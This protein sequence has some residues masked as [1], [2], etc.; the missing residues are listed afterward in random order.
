MNVSKKVKYT[1]DLNDKEAEALFYGL[2]ILHKMILQDMSDS[3]MAELD[4]TI[5]DFENHQ[6]RIVELFEDLHFAQ[7]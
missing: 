5:D 6:D 3:I 4:I 2:G 1:I 7:G